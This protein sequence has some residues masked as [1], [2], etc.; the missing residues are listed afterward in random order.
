MDQVSP[1]RGSGILA[2]TQLCSLDQWLASTNI[3]LGC[4]HS[5]TI[6][7]GTTE[8]LFFASRVW[9]PVSGPSQILSYHQF[10]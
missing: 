8:G 9:S 7:R 3:Y 5:L 6:G 4:P 1:G 10:L 2:L